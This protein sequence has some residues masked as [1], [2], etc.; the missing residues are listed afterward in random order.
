MWFIL[1]FL[2]PAMRPVLK[3]FK[4]VIVIGLVLSLIQMVVAVPVVA[5]E[6]WVGAEVPEAVYQGLCVVL[7]VNLLVFYVRRRRRRKRKRGA[8]RAVRR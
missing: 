7:F 6:R 3:L 1:S 8:G 2:S 5:W 4:M